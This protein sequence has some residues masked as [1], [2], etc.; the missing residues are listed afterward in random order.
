MQEEAETSPRP[1]ATEGVDAL[2]DV[3]S[4][5]K[6]YRKLVAVDEFSMRVAPGELVGLI[7]PNGAGK[8]TLMGCIAGTLAIDGGSIR[9]GDTDVSDAPVDARRHVGFVS[10]HLQL[11]DYLTGQEFLEF[12]AEVRGV[13]ADRAASRIEEL[14]AATEL[15]EAR[16]RL[17]KEYS[18]GMA[19]KLAVSSSLLGPPDLLL[20]DESFVGLD[21]ESAYHIRRELRNFRENGGAIVLSSHSL[22]MLRE[23]STRV[24][25]MADGRLCRDMTSSDID[26]AI[27]SGEFDN[28]TEIYL[29]ATGKAPASLEN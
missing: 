5:T 14:L 6:R 19:R 28:L 25:I 29:D 26:A 7:G 27:D 2:L 9:V 15:A 11:Y 17:V 3:D 8:S 18:G 12:V 4:V 1:D 21:P 13:P 22:E 23:I 16:N 10:Q 24:V 20:L